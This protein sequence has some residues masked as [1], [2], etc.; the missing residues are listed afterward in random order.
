MSNKVR[1]MEAP[2]CTRGFFLPLEAALNADAEVV[3]AE[4]TGRVAGQGFRAY[5]PVVGEPVPAEQG[6]LTRVVLGFLAA[7]IRHSETAAVAEG[8]G[9]LHARTGRQADGFAPAV[10]REPDPVGI[11]RQTASCQSRIKT[12]LAAL[13]DPQP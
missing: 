9:E 11:D 12:R 4:K 8:I 10:G 6:I 2:Q 13:R 3:Q 5:G 7:D 1:R